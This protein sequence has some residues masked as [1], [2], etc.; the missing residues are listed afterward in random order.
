MLKLKTLTLNG[1]G[2]FVE[3][4]TIDFTTLGNLVQVDGQNNNTG[5]S[6]GAGKSTVFHGLD[7]LFGLN[8]N[9]PNTALQSRLTKDALTVSG[10]FDWDGTPV[11]IER[12]K[13][14]SVQIG[15]TLTKGSNALA[16]EAID[17]LL[18]MDRKL[19]RKMLHKRQKEGGFFL[20]FTPKQTHEF[21]SSIL[22]LGDLKA[23]TEIVD[24]KIK[25]LNDLL[26]KLRTNHMGAEAAYKANLNALTAVGPAPAKEI[27]QEVVVGLKAQLDAAQAALEPIRQAHGLDME[28]LEIH[29]PQGTVQPY[30]Y[31]LQ[32]ELRAKVQSVQNH[33]NFLLDNERARKTTVNNQINELRVQKVRSDTLATRGPKALEEALAC[34]SE[35]KKIQASLCPTCEQTWVTEQAKIREAALIAKAKALGLEI[36]A[37]NEAAANSTQISAKITELSGQ[38]ENRYDGMAE[39]NEEMANLTQL[40][41]N[42]KSKEQEWTGSQ[43]TK[44]QAATAD[45]IAKQRALMV[46][47]N[48]EMATVNGQIQVA[49]AAF[50]AAVQKMQSYAAQLA[51][52]E[53][54]VQNLNQADQAYQAAM[55]KATQDLAAI[56]DELALAE[57]SKKMIKSFA[58][59]AF[60]GALDEVSEMAT[61]IVRAIPTMANATIQLEGIRETQDGKQNEEVNAVISMDGEINIPIKTFSGGERSS[62][63][64]AIDLAV[65]DLLENKTNKGI[66][67]FVLDEPFTGLDTVGIEMALEVLKNSNSRKRLVIVDHNPEVKQM[68]ASKLV[69]VRDGVTSKIAQ[70]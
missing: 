49:N 13:K 50:Q 54:T 44:N 66:D 17:S 59:C 69:V 25:E 47:H 26:T 10:E 60:D 42:D 16:E 27:T 41:I 30:D 40:I 61:R 18:G 29:R 37:G 6:S 2:R 67:L 70:S 28:A 4:Q 32:N 62:I 46:R 52:Y 19:F 21:L 22:G 56:S 55:V 24:K 20:Q 53:K 51:N 12:G 43:N 1:I 35:I 63:D 58:S 48:A 57:E 9:I 65:I 7:F 8:D 23:K 33:L 14:L 36:A 64:L 39:A 15:D 5:G 3:P 11:T 31:T 38:L 34:A 45:F 68:V